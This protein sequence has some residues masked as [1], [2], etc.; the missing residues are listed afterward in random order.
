[1]VSCRTDYRVAGRS[2]I[3]PTKLYDPGD[4]LSEYLF[5]RPTPM[6]RPGY[7][8]SGSVL[9]PRSLGVRLPFPSEAAHEE[10]GWWLLCVKQER[11]PLLMAE[12][13][14]FIQHIDAAVA[15]N[16]AQDW[17]ASLAWAR[18]YRPYMTQKAFSGLLSS[19]T[20]W[21]AK[22]QGG[23]QALRQ[24]AN[25]MACEGPADAKQWLM[26]GGI[27]L[28]PLGAVNNLRLRRR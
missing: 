12:Q 23:F 11:V 18:K 6:A 24:V 3:T 27:A 5:Y 10:M 13:A 9:F 17:R 21:R 15:R 28:L 8:A 7:I 25:A 16:Q 1:L 22:R 20:A 26:L 4:D 14:M 19:T 2:R